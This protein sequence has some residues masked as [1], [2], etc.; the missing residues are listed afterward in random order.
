MQ[1]LF[2]AFSSITARMIPS[3]ARYLELAESSV[4]VLLDRSQPATSIRLNVRTETVSFK[5][6]LT[7][8]EN[9]FKTR[10]NIRQNAAQIDKITS[11]CKY[12]AYVPSDSSYNCQQIIHHPLCE[13]YYLFEEGLASYSPPG[14]I[15][16]V[17][18]PPN[19]YRRLRTRTKTRIFGRG[20]FFQ[21]ET[22]H[23]LWEKKYAGAFASNAHTFPR[24]PPPVWNLGK[25]L[26]E[27]TPS[28]DTKLLVLDD[29]TAFSTELQEAYLKRI[30][31]LIQLVTVNGDTWAYKLH[32]VCEEWEW[33]RHRIE[34]M[35]NSLEGVQCYRRKLNRL[36]CIEDIGLS[37]GVI[38]Y[39]YMSSC[40]LYIHLGGGQAVCIKKFIEKHDP[41]FEAVWDMYISSSLN[42]IF[43]IIPSI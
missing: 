8:W 35:F 36:D 15:P 42:Q 17:K 16:I 19:S 14:E 27:P 12:V 41:R 30:A 34:G 2:Y 25:N 28:A 31:D 3:I 6:I 9:I 11:N 37:A 26:F 18:N 43:D 24:F 10:S 1:H 22:I 4:I 32:P 20:R 33:L 40:T 21:P 13:K 5:P 39:G 23:M 38:T 29:L 7:S